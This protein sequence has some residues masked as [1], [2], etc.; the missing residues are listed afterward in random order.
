MDL[1]FVVKHHNVSVLDW[2]LVESPCPV[3]NNTKKAI[4]DISR[5]AAF[6]SMELC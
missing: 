3:D 6:K 1:Y 2:I 5:F 4:A